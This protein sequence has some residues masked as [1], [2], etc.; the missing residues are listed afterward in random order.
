MKQNAEPT[1]FLRIYG[2]LEFTQRKL[3][4]S[5]ETLSAVQ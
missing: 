1:L 3:V 5:F 2:S 4:E